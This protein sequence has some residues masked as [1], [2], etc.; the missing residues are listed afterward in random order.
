MALA[1]SDQVG[2]TNVADLASWSGKRSGRSKRWKTGWDFR[3]RD[4]AG[5]RWNCMDVNNGHGTKWAPNSKLQEEK[6]TTTQVQDGQTKKKHGCIF[7]DHLNSFEYLDVFLVGDFL[8]SLQGRP[9][10]SSPFGPV[11]SGTLRVSLETPQ[12]RGSTVGP[13]GERGSG[14]QKHPETMDETWR[15]VGIY[16]DILI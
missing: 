3:P 9:R 13:P 2:S 6:R 10:P 14:H 12:T 16:Y 1:S 5:N 15:K 4:P 11:A 7:W 8:V